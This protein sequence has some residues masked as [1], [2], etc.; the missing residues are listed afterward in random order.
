M[1]K[2]T[3]KCI[4]CGREVEGREICDNCLNER[5]IDRIRREYLFK[6]KGKVSLNRF[7]K[8][9]LISIAR[10]NLTVMDEYFNSKNLFP[11]IIG[12]IKIHARRSEIIGSF[13]IQSGEIVDIIRAENIE[14]ITYKS[15]SKLS[16]LKWRSIR[17][18]KGEVDGVVTAWTLKNLMTAG[19]N[20]E[21][22]DIQPIII[23]NLE[24]N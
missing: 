23:E 10:R 12:R 3:Y 9:L 8:F 2:K 13:E 24:D 19:V 5:D 14:K 17:G 11:E 15:R 18:E 16:F 4:Y 22:L 6:L 7:R 1:L 20:L 21:D